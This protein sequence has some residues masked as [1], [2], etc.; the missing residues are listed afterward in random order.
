MAVQ[1]SS[2]VF[3]QITVISC[4]WLW[5]TAELKLWL[6]KIFFQR[7]FL[8]V[9]DAIA[10]KRK[11]SCSIKVAFHICDSTYRLGNTR[12]DDDKTI[13]PHSQ[14]NTAWDFWKCMHHD[15][16]K[17]SKFSML[18]K[19]EN[20]LISHLIF[21]RKRVLFENFG[22]VGL[23]IFIYS[24]LSNECRVANNRRVWKK[25]LDLINEGCGTNGGPGIF[26]RLNKRIAENSHFFR[27][28]PKF[29][30]I[31]FLNK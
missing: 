3:G 27:F 8:T 7:K 6:V 4:F 13:K 19:V 1:G 25:Y 18:W 11:H 12:A 5:K 2:N 14:I 17:A 21:G 9:R 26:A 16:I 10:S 15:R 24:Y 20:C 23:S 31:F 29:S 28:S 30:M 22:R